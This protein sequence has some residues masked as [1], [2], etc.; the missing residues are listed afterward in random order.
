LTFKLVRTR[1]QTRLPCEF[2]ASPFTDWQ[3]QKN[4]LPKFSA[5]GN[6]SK[7]HNYR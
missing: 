5:C 4:N 1:D 7:E 2:G 6:Y 3:H